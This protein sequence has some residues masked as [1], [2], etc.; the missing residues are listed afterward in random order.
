MASDCSIPLNLDSTEIVT[1]D[2]LVKLITEIAGKLV[3]TRHNMSMPQG[4][5][6]CRSDN[7]S[8]RD[9]LGWAPQ[10]TLRT[11]L[12]RS[13]A[14]IVPG[15]GVPEPGGLSMRDSQVVLRG[16]T[17]LDIAGGDVCEVAP[18][19]DPSGI[20]CIAAANLMFEI[21]CLI[22]SARTARGAG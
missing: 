8:L 4:V 3:R 18:P 21:L 10:V 2:Q 5:R 16:L 22:T 11:G 19:L 14:W 12:A 17:G 15:T 9:V 13:Y 6:V 7:T 20:T 1:V